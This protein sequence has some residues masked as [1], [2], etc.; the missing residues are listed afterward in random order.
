MQQAGG[1]SADSQGPTTL[2]IT[3]NFIAYRVLYNP[4]SVV[5]RLRFFTG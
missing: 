4:D 5:T 1:K 3:P 2:V